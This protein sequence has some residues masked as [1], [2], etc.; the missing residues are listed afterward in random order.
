MKKKSRSGCSINLALE[1]FGDK[2]TLLIIRDIMLGGKRHFREILKSDEKISTNILT[3]RLN[4]LEEQGILTK[5]NDSS[6]KQK[7]IYSL[8]EKGIDLLPVIASIAEWS[9]KH[10][11]VDEL[12]SK[13]SQYIVDGGDSL[14]KKFTEEL[15][16]K[17]LSIKKND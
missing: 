7:Y 17:H 8:T 11:A 5:E 15:K 4:M 9:L 6:H 12:S 10:E 14:I 2:W 13:H 3:N 16:E 1:V